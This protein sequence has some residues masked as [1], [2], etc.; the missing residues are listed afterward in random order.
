[1]DLLKNEFQSNPGIKQL[2]QAS[3]ESGNAA[4]DDII[5]RLVDARLQQ[6][7]CR[8]NGWVLDGFPETDAQ[9]NLLRAM[10][11]T[12]TRVIIFDM[13]VEESVRRLGQRRVDPH[14]GE[15]YDQDYN[16]PT[17]QVVQARLVADRADEEAPVRRRFAA[18]SEN[19]S[20]LEEHFRGVMKSVSAEKI[21]ESISDDVADL[22]LATQLRHK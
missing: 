2:V 19:V 18:W 11:I 17:S 6:S 21:I 22:V 10:K 4:P 12:P 13:P 9:V 1:M 7:D 3:L 20:N 15:V 16:K 8:V 14:T 5:L